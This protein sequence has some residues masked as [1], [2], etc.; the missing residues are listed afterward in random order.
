[1]LGDA[2][3][4]FEPFKCEWL[5]TPFDRADDLDP[6]AFTRLVEVKRHDHG[7]HCGGVAGRKRRRS[8]KVEEKED[9]TRG[10][11]CGVKNV[12]SERDRRKSKSKGRGHK[13][14]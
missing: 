2:G 11:R 9:A 6:L 13:K 12:S 8:T 10:A 14:E 4:I 5:V 1:M 3:S 7:W